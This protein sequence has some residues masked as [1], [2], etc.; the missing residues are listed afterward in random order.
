M[1]LV[2]RIK[3]PHTNGEFAVLTSKEGGPNLQLN[4]YENKK[5]Y[6]NGDELDHPGFLVDDAY[7]E[8]DRL[9]ALGVEIAQEPHESSNH[10][11]FFAKDPDGI[12]L[13][14]FSKKHKEGTRPS[15]ITL[16]ISNTNP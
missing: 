11:V 4:W 6:T 8:L 7:K 12:W 1:K 2:S 15:L 5:Q 14:I 16:N 9:K 10:V 13:E 3:N